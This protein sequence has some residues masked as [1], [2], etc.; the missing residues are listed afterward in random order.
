VGS[1]ERA[2]ETAVALGIEHVHIV[3]PPASMSLMQRRAYLE[4]LNH[5]LEPLHVLVQ[6]GHPMPSTLRVDPEPFEGEHADQHAVFDPHGEHGTEIRINPDPRLWNQEDAI[7]A[8]EVG[9]YS[10]PDPRGT[11]YHEYL[12]FR[13]F[14]S[15]GWMY[16]A[17]RSGGLC[18]EEVERLSPRV[19][20]YAAANAL[21]FASEVYAA[22]RTGR[23][24]YDGEVMALYNKILTLANLLEADL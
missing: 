4:I 22:I 11:T 9:G 24:A 5:V 14:A 1:F 18:Q 2:R 15:S 6:E 21:E 19:S 17:L 20:D 16:V 7:R 8:H 13:V 12:H 3:D 23:P 10:T